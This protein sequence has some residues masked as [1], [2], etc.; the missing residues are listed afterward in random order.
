MKSHAR[1]RM[2]RRHVR[3]SQEALAKAVG[4]RRSAVSHWE[5]PLGK[6]PTVTNLC[7]IAEVTAVQFEW[8]ATGRGTM[9]LTREVELDS[10]ETAFAVLIED[11]LEVRMIQAIRSIPLDS[12]MSLLELAEQLVAL[13]LG[14]KARVMELAA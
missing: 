6:V 10:V 7:K 11:Q 5:A 3:L 1:I 9:A 12:R 4:V 2:A 13:R 14:R 8:L